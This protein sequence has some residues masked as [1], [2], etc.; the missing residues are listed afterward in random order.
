LWCDPANAAASPLAAG[1]VLDCVVK[2]SERLRCITVDRLPAGFMNRLLPE[3]HELIAQLLL[4]PMGSS[5]WKGPVIPRKR[6]EAA[7]R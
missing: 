7:K 4:V 3:Q 1:G 2:V 6:I 5:R